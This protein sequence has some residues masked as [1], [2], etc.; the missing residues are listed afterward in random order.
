MRMACIYPGLCI[1]C[2]SSA[3]GQTAFPAAPQ[4]VLVAL[5]AFGIN[6]YDRTG[7]WTLA[8]DPHGSGHRVT[9]V[10]RGEVPDWCLTGASLVPHWCPPPPAMPL[11]WTRRFCSDKALLFG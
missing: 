9:L 3:L 10:L 5:H 4:Q 1:A 11:I 8:N 6:I 2:P 7:S